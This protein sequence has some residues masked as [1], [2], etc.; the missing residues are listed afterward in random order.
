MASRNAIPLNWT[1]L[2]GDTRLNQLMALHVWQKVCDSG[3]D[4]T[5]LVVKTRELRDGRL[6]LGFFRSEADD[7]QK[8][9]EGLGFIVPMGFWWTADN[10]MPLNWMGVEPPAGY[11]PPD[12]TVHTDL[13][14]L[15]P[16]P[17]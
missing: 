14:L 7:F 6:A 1:L 13:F 9:I 15:L 10:R 11:G 5:T 16:P 17:T 4:P 2:S 12:G 8:P 3:Q